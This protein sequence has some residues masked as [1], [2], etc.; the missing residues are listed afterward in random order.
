MV[1]EQNLYQI[2]KLSGKFIIE[3]N[4]DIKS[5]SLKQAS[6][7]GNI[8][9]IGDNI[10]FDCIR[11]YK[12]DN[13]NYKEIFKQI[14]LCRMALN[15]A[16]KEGDIGVIRVLNNAIRKIL[17]VKDIVN[18]EYQNKSEHQAVARAGF[19][20]NGIRYVRFSAGAGQ[21]RRQTVTF[22]NAD[23]YDE[24]TKRL[25]CGLDEKIQEIN[26]AKLSAYFA[27]STS[28]VLWVDAPRCCV[29]KDFDTVVKN[30][31]VDWI[32]KDE[33]GEGYVE[34]R[35]MDIELNSADGQGLI[36]PEWAKHWSENMA[37]D[38][39]P[40]SFVVR[41]CFVKGNLVP[42]DFKEYARRH[43]ITTI[44]DKYGKEYNIEDIDCLLSE[45]Q[46]KMH[47]YYKSWDEY[48]KYFNKYNL[49]WGVARYNKKEDPEYSL[50][51][52]QYIQVLSLSEQDIDNLIAPTIDWLKKICSGDDLYALLYSFGGFGIDQ[53]I[54]YNDIYTRAQNLAMKAVV[55]DGRFL[56]DTYIQKKIYKNIVEAINKC[57][58]GKIWIRGNYQFCISDPIAQCR[59]ALGLSPDGAIPADNVYCNFWNN[60]NIE[61]MV[62]ICRSPMI[63]KHEHNPCMLYRDEETD[64]WYRHIQSGCIFSI[65]DTSV[66]RMEDS[67]LT[68]WVRRTATFGRNL[69]NL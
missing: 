54:S 67:D 42:F 17:F 3:N 8:V 19:Y 13:R 11:Q 56:H 32:C 49:K 30:Q 64:Y 59:S 10:L 23:L 51:N 65:Y 43:N 28:S 25:M 50:V 36:D 5:Y 6:Q 34:E 22:I 16:K 61:G 47:K 20:L 24:M 57:K 29:I 40:S 60:R 63:D 41:S 37:L 66:C 15:R 27:L 33:N 68:Q 69:V 21:L 52:Y 18:V 26:L 2:L 7:D 9:S 31:K 12:G 44:K 14:S 55:K 1:R 35:L 38:Y 62:D 46:F 45:S 4:F 58:I 53:S 39:V 48:L